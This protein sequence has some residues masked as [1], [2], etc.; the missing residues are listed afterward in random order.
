MQRGGDN[1]RSSAGSGKKVERIEALS[2]RV[3]LGV[4]HSQTNVWADA[5]QKEKGVHAQRSRYSLSAR[6]E[7]I[8]NGC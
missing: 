8:T 3:D 4:S 1:A 5:K 7:E 6:G 2:S